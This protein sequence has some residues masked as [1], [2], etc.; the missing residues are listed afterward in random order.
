[1]TKLYY[2]DPLAAAYMAREFGVKMILGST[3]YSIKKYPSLLKEYEDRGYVSPRDYDFWHSWKKNFHTEKFYI[4]PEQHK[5]FEPKEG[6]VLMYSEGEKYGG[7]LRAAECFDTGNYINIGTRGV[8]SYSCRKD[9]ETKI[10]F[11]EHKIIQ[12]DNKPFFMPEI[13]K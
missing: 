4:D 7:R 3:L 6:D 12:R 1:M 10:P 13:L 5:I 11:R 2:T 9:A 8:I